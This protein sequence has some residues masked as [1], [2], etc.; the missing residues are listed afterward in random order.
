MYMNDQPCRCARRLTAERE[1]ISTGIGW[2]LFYSLYSDVLVLCSCCC[3]VLSVFESFKFPLDSSAVE[4]LVWK[5]ICVGFSLICWMNCA[6]WCFDTH[7]QSKIQLLLFNLPKGFYSTKHTAFES[8]CRSNRNIFVKALKP[9]SLN[10]S[11]NPTWI[12]PFMYC[13]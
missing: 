5:V 9:V 1:I 8:V 2:Y 13:F 7:V 11:S 6:L 10:F 4:L 3:D 12:L